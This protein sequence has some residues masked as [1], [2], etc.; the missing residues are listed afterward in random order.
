MK[1]KKAI[2]ESVKY[3]H[4]HTQ[5]MQLHWFVKYS[6]RHFSCRFAKENDKIQLFTK[7][8]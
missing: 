8:T 7:S 3:I 2:L 4:I 5:H 1:R 6:Y